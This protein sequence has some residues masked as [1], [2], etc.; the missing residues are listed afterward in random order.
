MFSSIVRRSRK[1]YL[2]GFDPKALAAA[3][4]APKNDPWARNEV[5]RYTGP[6]TRANRFKNLF[7][8]FGTA[9]I[10]FAAYCTYEHFFL[11][12]SHKHDEGDEKH[13]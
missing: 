4:G 3:A 2:S 8:G 1:T 6:F 11:N 13:H 10:A 5:W 7:P 12:Q 9:T